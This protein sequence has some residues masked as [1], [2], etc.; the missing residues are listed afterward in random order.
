MFE[1][2]CP[3]HRS[4]VLLSASRIEA[5]HN[6]SEGPILDW[7]CW[8]GARGSLANGRRPIRRHRHGP[9]PDAA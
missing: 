9:K 3:S 2:Y 4:R 5:I 1:V 7:H 8:C 6:T